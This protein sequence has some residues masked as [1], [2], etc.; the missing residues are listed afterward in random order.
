MFRGLTGREGVDP[1]PSIAILNTAVVRVPTARAQNEG[2]EG[3]N[4]MYLQGI[5]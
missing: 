1:G 3:Q 4:I 2:Y 5:D